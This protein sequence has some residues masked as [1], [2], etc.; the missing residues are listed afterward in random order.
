MTEDD[1]KKAA[2]IRLRNL[3]P[4]VGRKLDRA[5]HRRS[6]HDHTINVFTGLADEVAKLLGP[7]AK[8]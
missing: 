5:V 6:S 1:R 4:R 2:L 7:S 8:A 3:L